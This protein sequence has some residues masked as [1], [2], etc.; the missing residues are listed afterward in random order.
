MFGVTFGHDASERSFL[1]FLYD[2]KQNNAIRTIMSKN[3]TVKMII[4]AKGINSAKNLHTA[5][6]LDGI[7]ITP[8]KTAHP[9]KKVKI[10][11][12]VIK[13]FFQDAYLLNFS[14]PACG[15]VSFYISYYT[16]RIS[17]RQS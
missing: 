3:T 1:F 7:S 8:A 14:D 17:K 10:L 16:I 9:I 15:S 13:A 4:T 11:A 12:A 2:R 6:S 5:G